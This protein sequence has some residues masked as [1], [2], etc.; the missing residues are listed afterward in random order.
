M[1]RGEKAI[2]ALFRT[3]IRYSHVYRWTTSGDMAHHLVL[4]NSTESAWTTGPALAVADSG[5]LSEDLLKYVPKGGSGELPVTTAINIAH[6]RTDTEIDRKLKAYNPSTN[7]F[8]DLVRLKGTI[9]L[10]NFEKRPVRVVIEAPV[11]GKPLLASDDGDIW[12]NT[13]KL[14]LLQREGIVRWT[15]ELKP[16]EKKTLTFEFERYV[17]SQ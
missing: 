2:V 6:E 17:P 1:R 8:V 16:D 11:E 13:Q 3:K 14:Q 15:L 4:H 10:K 12:V 5:P 7:F 9:L